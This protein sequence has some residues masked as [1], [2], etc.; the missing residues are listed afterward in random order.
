MIHVSCKGQ[1]CNAYDVVGPWHP[2]TTYAPDPADPL[3]PEK[4]VHVITD[5]TAF[6]HEHADDCQP[7]PETGHYPL[8]FEFMAAVGESG[9]AV[10]VSGA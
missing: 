4:G 5:R 3:N 7:H 8:A 6:R 10:S 9:P 1:G 2:A